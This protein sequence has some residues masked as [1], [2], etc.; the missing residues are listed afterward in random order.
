MSSNSTKHKRGSGLDCVLAL[1]VNIS[2]K[3]SIHIGMSILRERSTYRL[4]NRLMLAA[5]ILLEIT[6]LS[7]WHDLEAPEHIVS[8]SKRDGDGEYDLDEEV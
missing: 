6:Y 5:T 1:S 3:G 2:R 7:S 8:T 4:S